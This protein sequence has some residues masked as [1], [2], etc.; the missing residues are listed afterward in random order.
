M[1]IRDSDMTGRKRKTKSLKTKSKRTIY[2]ELVAT[3]QRQYDK[4]VKEVAQ[5]YP[6]FVSNNTTGAITQRENR[7][8]TQVKESY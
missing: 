3:Q 7:C 6:S 4:V 2:K 1:C 5:H 8:N